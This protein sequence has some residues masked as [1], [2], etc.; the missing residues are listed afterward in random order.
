MNEEVINFGVLKRTRPLKYL[1]QKEWDYLTSA[2]V[3]E[4]A[5]A[6]VLYVAV[7]SKDVG[8]DSIPKIDSTVRTF[9]HIGNGN[10]SVYKNKLSEFCAFLYP[11]ITKMSITEELVG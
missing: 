6:I 9:H 5:K 10:S 4:N 3:D 8:V 7:I 2:R 1:G 11:H